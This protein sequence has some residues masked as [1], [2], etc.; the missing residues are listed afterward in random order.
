[1]ASLGL[2]LGGL[3]VGQLRPL[4]RAVA[5]AAGGGAVAAAL[6]L[7]WSIE[8]LAPGA[9]WAGFAGLGPSV[10]ASP[11][12]GSLVRFDT[13][14]VGGVLGWA[15]L[16]AAA[17]PLVLGRGWRFSWAARLWVMA[18]VLWGVA[19]V[20]GRGW[21]GIPPPDVDVLLA[22]AAAGIVLAAVLG[23]SA[24]ELDLP[25]YRFGWPQVAALTAA[26]AAA[27]SLLPVLSATVDGHWRQPRRDVRRLLS[28]MPERRADG[29]FRVLWAGRPQTLPLD[30]WR[31]GEGLAY[32]SSRNG[33]PTVTDLWPASDQGSTGLLADALQVA[34][35][36]ETSRLGHLLAPLG[37]RYVAVP[38]AVAAGAA[39]PAP[40]ADVLA[41]L[42]AQIDLKLIS[43]DSS[44]VVYENAAWAPI[45]NVLPAGA[46]AASHRAGPDAART[47]ELT[48]AAAALR[49][50]RRPTE[51]TGT[52]P[53]AGE[54]AVAE[55]YSSRWSLSTGGRHA[56][57]RKAFGW[58]N[59]FTVAAKGPGT[60]RYRT[61]P[62]RY[63]ALLLELALWA[64]ALRFALAGI[65]ERREQ[66]S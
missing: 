46:V 23:L 20:A 58:S 14:P 31:L 52:V 27:A 15:F 43:S 10:A 25:A 40:P 34:R 3:L 41:A 48:G 30:G 11:G 42:R 8:V 26:A 55:A 39:K 22:P 18:M 12:L 56:P 4:V 44:L 9:M 57:H 63:A 47:I 62:V 49:V 35:R 7:P 60:L 16:V 17:L 28:R 24:F 1:V 54:V 33:T 45:R 64:F 13:G 50:E 51:F 36:G 21:L 59:A 5:V 37:V 66:T 2:V 32:G 19:W 53:A 29:D 38:L 61:P 6:L 65:R